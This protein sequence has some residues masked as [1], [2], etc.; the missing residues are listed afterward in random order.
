VS[1]ISNDL[2]RLNGH[3]IH[4]FTTIDNESYTYSQMLWQDDYTEFFHTM[5]VE[6]DDHETRKHWSLMLQSDM[7]VETKTFM[8]I[9]SFKCK[10]FSAGSLNKHKARLCAHGGQQT[11]GQDYWET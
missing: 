7:P 11:W 9:W 3:H 1:E 5:E 4:A 8:T 6:L 2:D 10:R